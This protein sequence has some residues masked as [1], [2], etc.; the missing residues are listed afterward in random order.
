MVAARLRQKSKEKKMSIVAGVVSFKAKPGKGTELAHAIAAALP[1]V[2][3][4]QGTPLWLVLHSNAEPEVVFLVDLF[5]SPE[6]RNTH[7]SGDAARQ[8]F[9]AIPELLAEQPAL[10]P[11]DLVA[12]KGFAA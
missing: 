8:I 9:A 1:H 10:H 2:E 5:N 12:H 11:S 6:D 7:M 3:K 4:E